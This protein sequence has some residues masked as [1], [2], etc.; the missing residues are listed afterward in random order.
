MVVE[1]GF[2]IRAGVLCVKF[3]G[4]RVVCCWNWVG[5]VALLYTLPESAARP[6][7]R[8]G[9]EDAAFFGIFQKHQCGSG[10]APGTV[11][12]LKH[13]GLLHD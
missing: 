4:S 6:S 12:G 2:I 10:A 8:E 9:A 1:A 5:E 11:A 7:R 3:E 13:V